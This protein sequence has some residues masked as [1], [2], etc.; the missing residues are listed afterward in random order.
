MKTVKKQITSGV[1]L[2]LSKTIAFR[3]SDGDML[4]EASIDVNDYVS[5]IIMR[6]VFWQ[7]GNRI[8]NVLADKSEQIAP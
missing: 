6:D 7:I 8:H 4:W 2:D 3:G 5:R 1:Y